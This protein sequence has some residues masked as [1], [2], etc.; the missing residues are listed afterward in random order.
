MVFFNIPCDWFKKNLWQAAN[1]FVGGAVTTG[2]SNTIN[3]HCLSTCL[4][5]TCCW[6]RVPFGSWGVEIF[7]VTS[8]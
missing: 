7:L 6:T 2:K 5:V 1:K 8:C 4:W 3:D